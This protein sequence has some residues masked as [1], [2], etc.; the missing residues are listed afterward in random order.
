MQSKREILTFESLLIGYKSGKNSKVLLP[1]LT[2]SAHEGEL[3]A[4]VGQNGIGKSTLLRT[5]AGLQDKLGG[6]VV[7]NGKQ[8]SSYSRMD[9]AQNIGYISTEPVKVINMKVYDLVALGRFPH[10]GWLGKLSENDHIVIKES[11]DK[12]GLNLFKNRYITELSD[13]ERQRVMI[14]RV[15]AQDT[16]LLVM[17][18]P[19][20]FLDLKSKY[21]IIHLLHDL[22]KKRG[23]TIIF[24]THDLNTALS[25]ADKMWLLL[26]DLFVEGAPE[27]LIIKGSFDELF[28]DSLVRFNNKDGSFTFRNEYKGSVSIKG[29]GIARLWTEKALN[30]AGYFA[31]SEKSDINIEVISSIE[32]YKWYV[33][34]KNIRSESRSIYDLVSWITENIG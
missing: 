33:D 27:D 1:S 19:T 34:H 24:S 7:I 32:G 12:V 20:A 17:D 14:A 28:R 2:A 9:F 3:I 13:G 5:I 21:E 16:D 11:I 30:R 31:V 6:T 29:D 15:L 8:I 4:I 18:E 25:E 23:K 26:K 22:S 10:T